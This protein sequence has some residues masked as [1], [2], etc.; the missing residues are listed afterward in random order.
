MRPLVIALALTVSL[1]GSCGG[2]TGRSAS[3]PTP[4]AGGT[5]EDFGGS[6]VACEDV[7]QL[8]YDETSSL[9]FSARQVLDTIEGTYVFPI[10]WIAPCEDGSECHPP[11]SCQVRYRWH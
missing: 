11:A 6:A 3:K 10:R 8:N 7:H 4:A 1:C 5:T 9:G 2:E